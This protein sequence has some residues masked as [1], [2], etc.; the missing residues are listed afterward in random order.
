[1]HQTYAGIVRRLVSVLLAPAL[2]AVLAAPAVAGEYDEALKGVKGVKVVFDY[3][4]GAPKMSNAL[5][6]AVRNVYEDKSVRALPDPPRVVIVFRGAA[7]KLVSSDRKSFN[8]SDKE[9]LD[10]FA[11]TIRQ[12]KK[13][14]V[15]MEVCLYAAKSQ[16]IDPATIMSEIDPV[17]NGFVSVAGYQAQ[18][19]AVI[20]P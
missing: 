15:R 20:V 7:V 5:F 12:L 1:M 10:K 3:N 4:Q 13:D 2:V 6:W 18:G 16:G 14:G 11:D 9:D 17:G 19:Y 8:E